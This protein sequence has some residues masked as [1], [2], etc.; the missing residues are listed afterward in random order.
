MECEWKETRENVRKRSERY[1][2]KRR[3]VEKNDENE[4][5]KGGGGRR[6][7]KTV[8]ARNTKKRN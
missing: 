7:K 6:K 4:N 5:V 1:R 3:R 2:L 8:D